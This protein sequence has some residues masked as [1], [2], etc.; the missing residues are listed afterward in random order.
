M[1]ISDREIR[2]IYDVLRKIE[3]AEKR[4][5]R[6]NYYANRCGDIRL[7]LKKVERKEKR[8]LL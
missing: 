8:R 1:E 5:A 2:R 4:G 6:K 7:V 3:I